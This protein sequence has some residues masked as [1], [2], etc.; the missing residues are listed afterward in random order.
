M[1]EIG[2]RQT[3]RQPIHRPLFTIPCSQFTIIIPSLPRA[4][5]STFRYTAS[6]VHRK[7][8]TIHVIPTSVHSCPIHGA[9]VYCPLSTMDPPST[10]LLPTVHHL[11]MQAAEWVMEWELAVRL[12]NSLCILHLSPRL[13]VS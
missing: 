2:I 4:L 3:D 12:W 13:H 9:T 1:R 8:P 10:V 7:T 6:T 5:L 11:F